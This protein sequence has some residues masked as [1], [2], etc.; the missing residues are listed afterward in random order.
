MDRTPWSQIGHLRDQEFGEDS[1]TGAQFSER[2]GQIVSLRAEEQYR[3][4]MARKVAL[5]DD[6]K[7]IIQE[8]ETRHSIDFEK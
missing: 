3:S 6:L 4:R 8:P 1:P 2:L 7:S 5:N